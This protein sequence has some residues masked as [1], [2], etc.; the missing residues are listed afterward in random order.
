L[1]NDN[2]KPNFGD[3]FRDEWIVLRSFRDFTI[4]HKHLKSQVRVSELSVGT[5]AKIV[6]AATGLAAAAFTIGHQSAVSMHTRRDPL[7]PSLDQATKVGAV[8]GTRRN[9]EKRRCKLGIY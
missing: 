6:E 7:I 3:F 4:L 2:I 8:G 9:I 5:G 1:T